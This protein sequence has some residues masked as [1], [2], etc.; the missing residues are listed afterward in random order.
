MWTASRGEHKPATQRNAALRRASA[1]PLAA[2]TLLVIAATASAGEKLPIPDA[3]DRAAAYAEKTCENDDSCAAPGV[4]N[5]RRLKDR[6][7]LCRIYDHRK[8]EE[9]GNFVCTR[10]VRLALKLPSH[11]SPVTSVTDWDC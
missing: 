9:Q 3:R 10:L 5:C 2:A 6:V 1:L 8:T 4:Q 11:K 7:V